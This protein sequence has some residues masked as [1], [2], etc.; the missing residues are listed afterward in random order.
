MILFDAS[1]EPKKY[2]KLY[3]H[4]DI[5]PTLMSNYF[6]VKSPMN[7]YSFGQNL[8]DIQPREWFVSGYNNNYEIIEKDRITKVFAT[9][10]FDITDLDLNPIKEAELNYD[11]LKNALT[12]INKFYIKK[13]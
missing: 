7:T 6:G 8:L 12:E 10:L 11:V 5:V 1:K 2:N 3:L 4:Y 9:C 13:E